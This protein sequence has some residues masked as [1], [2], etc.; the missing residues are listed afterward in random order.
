MRQQQS[1]RVGDEW[2]VG[3]KRRSERVGSLGWVIS[4]G[5]PG[6]SE[7]RISNSLSATFNC[8]FHLQSEG[9]GDVGREGYQRYTGL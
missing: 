2:L 9:E 7:G 3:L 4:R 8:K 5:D 6:C 1:S